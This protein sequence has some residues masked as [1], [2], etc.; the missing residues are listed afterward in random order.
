MSWG[1]LARRSYSPRGGGAPFQVFE[2]IVNPG[3]NILI[4]E[5]TFVQEQFMLQYTFLQKVSLSHNK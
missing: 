5:P 1:S 2:M 4:N 3:D